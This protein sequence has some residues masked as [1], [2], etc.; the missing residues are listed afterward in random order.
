MCGV[1]VDLSASSSSSWS[2]AQDDDV[3]R[4]QPQSEPVRVP[5][6]NRVVG[7]VGAVLRRRLSMAA[8]RTSEID[9][10]MSRQRIRARL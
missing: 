1:S 7:H 6:S 4:R 10:D 3:A 2:S 5:K 9:R 8:M